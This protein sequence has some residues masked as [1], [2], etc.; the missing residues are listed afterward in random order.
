MSGQILPDHIRPGMKFPV[1]KLLLPLLPLFF[2]AAPLPAQDPSPSPTLAERVAHDPV[3]AFLRAWNYRITTT[4]QQQIQSDGSVRSIRSVITVGH[5]VLAAIALIL[6]LIV[7]GR[8]ARAFGRY[9]GRRFAIEDAR[10]DVL[11]K[12]LFVL[13]ALFAIFT[14]LNW[15]QIPL[16]TFAFLGGALAIG[17]GFG[18]QTIMNNLISG[19]IVMAEQQI[20]LGDVIEVDG[21]RGQVARMGARCLTLITGDGAEFLVPNSRLVSNNVI[22]WTLANSHQRF[23]LAV[24]LA[25]GTPVEKAISVL[26]EA[27]KDIPQILMDRPRE[28]LFEDFANSALTFRLYYWLDVRSA[29]NRLI[30]SAVRRNIDRLCREAGIEIPFPQRDIRLH[31]TEPVPVKIEGAPKDA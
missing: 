1:Q 16:A 9:A 29:D 21:Q 13:L 11:Q 23:S 3:H 18:T 17:I 27:M 30:S 31:A 15:L 22:N 2:A 12:I 25:Y 10:R 20:K 6:G 7:S 24:G 19:V 26:A 4:E 14:V 8:I 28:V 5:V